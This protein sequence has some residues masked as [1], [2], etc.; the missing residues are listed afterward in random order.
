MKNTFKK[1]IALMLVIAFSISCMAVSGFA[2]QNSNDEDLGEIISVQTI[3]LEDGTE[4][5]ET[6]YKKQS[7]IIYYDGSKDVT[8]TKKYTVS[9]SNQYAKL[10]A[11]FRCNFAMQEVSCISK[12]DESNLDGYKR[13]SLTNSVKSTSCSAILK[14]TFD[15]WGGV[16]NGSIK[17]A[18]DYRGNRVD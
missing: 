14:F 6:V 2:A 16:S 11:T 1:I 13:K 8:F 5:L 15:S 10:T 18:C 7:D 9:N 3:I 4:V 17:I 12:Q